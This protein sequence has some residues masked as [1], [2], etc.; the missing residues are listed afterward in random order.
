M[1]LFNDSLTVRSVETEKKNNLQ[2]INN[3]TIIQNHKYQD[4]CNALETDVFVTHCWMLIFLSFVFII[5]DKSGTN[6]SR[7]CSY[8]LV[9]HQSFA[10]YEQW[11]RDLVNEDYLLFIILL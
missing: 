7:I 6:F 1:P 2:N 10:P 8:S 4:I 3:K 5:R 11:Q 9:F